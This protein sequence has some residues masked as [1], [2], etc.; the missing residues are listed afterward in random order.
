MKVLVCGGREYAD[1]DKVNEVLTDIHKKN[2]IDI[3]I[4]GGAKGADR[5][6][7]NWTVDND[8][9]VLVYTADWNKH[10]RA[11]GPIRNRRM[12]D[13]QH[14]D[15]VV[16]FPGGNGTAHMVDIAKKDGVPVMEIV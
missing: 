11:A 3:L 4:H 14:P 8:V 1:Q 6:A 5:L 9:T 10:G 2:P 16:A 12:L 15:L 13:E 7:W